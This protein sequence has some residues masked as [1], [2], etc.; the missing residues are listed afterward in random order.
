MKINFQLVTVLSSVG[1]NIASTIP[2][3]TRYTGIGPVGC[4][5]NDLT[6]PEHWKEWDCRYPRQSITDSS[7]WVDGYV[8]L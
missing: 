2:P 8:I 6:K 4:N 5:T 7:L 1:I 3:S